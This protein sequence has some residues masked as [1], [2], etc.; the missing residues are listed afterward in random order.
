[1]RLV[2]VVLLLAGSGASAS[3]VL[4]PDVVAGAGGR[5]AVWQTGGPVADTVLAVEPSDLT[6][7]A[8]PTATPDSP[9]A[10]MLPSSVVPDVTSWALLMLGMAIIGLAARRRKRIVTA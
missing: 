7:F 2:I 8:V 10:G 4:P 6:G 1:M 3:V 9:D 5:T